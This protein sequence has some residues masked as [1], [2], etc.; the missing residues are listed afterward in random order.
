MKPILSEPFECIALDLVGLLPKAK[1]G[2]TDVLT[3]ICLAT[4]WPEATDLKS[5]TAKAI[6]EAMLEVLGRMG[7]PSQILT[8]NR[9]QFKSAFMADVTKYL[10]INAVKTTPYHPQ[11]NRGS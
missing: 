2:V 9:G 4:R 11:A 6:A 5:I 7:L 8:D 3:A 1:G 10:G